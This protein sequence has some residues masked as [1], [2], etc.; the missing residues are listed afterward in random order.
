MRESANRPMADGGWGGG[1]RGAG[2]LH[3]RCLMR[4]WRGAL[5]GAGWAIGLSVGVVA[6]AWPQTVDFGKLGD[7]ALRLTQEYLRINTTNPPGNENRT[8]AFFAKIFAAEGIPFDTGSSAPGR[9]NVWARLKGGS[10]PALVLLHHMDVVPADPKYW[11][12]RSVRG[13][14]QGRIPVRAGGARHQIAGHLRADGVPGAPSGPGAAR[15]G[16]DLRRHGGRRGGGQLRG[17]LDGR[18]PCR[19]LSGGGV[20]DQRGRAA[21]ASPRAGR[22]TASR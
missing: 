13:H 15:S 16:R 2:Y 21:A 18:A 9:G 6:T 5:R 17:R 22:P 8:A 12:R 7:E 10:E 19:G 11:S 1:A 14:D 4:S 20:S 3:G